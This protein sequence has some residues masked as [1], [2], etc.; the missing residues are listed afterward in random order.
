MGN[1]SS[2][3]DILLNRMKE[4][5]TISTS[6]KS[7]TTGLSKTEEEERFR[8]WQAEAEA[9]RAAAEAKNQNIFERAW[10]TVTGGVKGWAGNQ[11]GFFGNI[12]EGLSRLGE[13]LGGPDR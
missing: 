2:A 9:A 7:T 11:A 3:L 13:R 6:P 12:A 8:K 5:G 4:T 10:N 1:Q